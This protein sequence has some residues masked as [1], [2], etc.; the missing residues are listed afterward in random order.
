MNEKCGQAWLVFIFFFNI[1]PEIMLF[2]IFFA[3]YLSW[4]VAQTTGITTVSE[5]EKEEKEALVHYLFQ[6]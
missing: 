6:S 2:K 4:N 5:E 3:H 1:H